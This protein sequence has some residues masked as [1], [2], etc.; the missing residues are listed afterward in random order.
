MKIKKILTHKLNKNLLKAI[1]KLKRSH[2]KF[3][4]AS[5]YSWFKKYSFKND[6]HFLLFLK[7]ELIGYAHLGKR[8]LLTINKKDQKKRSKYILFR[9]FV[10]SK[11]YRQIGIGSKMMISLND[12]FKRSKKISLLITRKELV[13]YYK[14]KNWIILKKKSFSIIDHKHNLFG[15]V[16]KKTF[17]SPDKKYYFYYNQ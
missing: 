11:K 10:I 3:S 17:N 5:Q 2:W 12:F 7:K 13:N 8:T 16:F 6:V 4:Y 1:I 15:M 9:T 14:K